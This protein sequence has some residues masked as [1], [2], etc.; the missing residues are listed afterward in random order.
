MLC[1]Y[2]SVCS[3]VWPYA[4]RCCCFGVGGEVLACPIQCVAYSRSTATVFCCFFKYEITIQYF[5]LNTLARGQQLF[6]FGHS[7]KKQLFPHNKRICVVFVNAVVALMV[8]IALLIWPINFNETHFLAMWTHTH[9]HATVSVWTL[10]HCLCSRRRLCT[11]VSWV[12]WVHHNA[13]RTQHFQKQYV[14]LSIY[15]IKSMDF[16]KLYSESTNLISIE[17]CSFILRKY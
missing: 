10:P 6:E 14:I 17:L 3:A 15:I 16:L 12:L 13:C 8:A 4:G 5:W 7:A 1:R 9:T 11:R 2:R